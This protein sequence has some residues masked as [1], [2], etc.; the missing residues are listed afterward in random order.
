MRRDQIMSGTH[1]A[2]TPKG[3]YG[4]C[5]PKPTF[6]NAV[7]DG[8]GAP[9]PATGAL[10]AGA[11]PAVDLSAEATGPASGVRLPVAALEALDDVEPVVAAVVANAVK[12][13]IVRLAVPN[14]K[15]KTEPEVGIL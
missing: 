7:A 14:V 11:A 12:A 1:S 3:G 4:I 13:C 9:E 15:V 2:R 5:Q 6:S 10:G 8:A